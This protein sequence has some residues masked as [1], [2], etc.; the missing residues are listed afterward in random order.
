MYQY[1]TEDRDLAGKGGYEPAAL[2]RSPSVFLARPPARSTLS[3]RAGHWERQ[4]R[5][6]GSRLVRTCLAQPVPRAVT[7]HLADDRVA[8][9]ASVIAGRLP[10]SGGTTAI[11]SAAVGDAE[12]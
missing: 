6:L 1:S 12:R 8:R 5:T 9:I 11:G 7:A 4:H 2:M 10:R 3:G